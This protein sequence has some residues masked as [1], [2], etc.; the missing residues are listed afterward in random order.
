MG[1][2][3]LALALSTPIG[4]W[5]SIHGQAGSESWYGLES[6]APGVLLGPGKVWSGTVSSL[7]SGEVSR[8]TRSSSLLRHSSSHFSAMG[9][10]H[11]EGWG[12]S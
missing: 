12:E 8:R 3:N 10:N 5:C 9:Q 6:V 11:S 4:L 1:G 7:I 2:N